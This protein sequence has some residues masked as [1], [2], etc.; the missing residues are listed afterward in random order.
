MEVEWPPVREP[1]A[2]RVWR[3]VLQPIAAQMR[4]SAAELTERTVSHIQAEA[5]ELL[6]DDQII[7][8]ARSGTEESLSQLAQLI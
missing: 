2:Q 1:G 6:P 7:E 5:P 4:R 3:D 8:E